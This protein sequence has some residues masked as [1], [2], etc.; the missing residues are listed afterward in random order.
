[1]L[2]VKT[3]TRFLRDQKLAGKRGRDIDKLEAIVNLLGLT[4]PP[5]ICDMAVFFPTLS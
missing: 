4:Y 5:S 2:S 1:M 3:T